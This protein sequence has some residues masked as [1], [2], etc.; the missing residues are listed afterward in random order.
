MLF[1][2]KVDS[3]MDV[4]GIRRINNIFKK[5]FIRQRDRPFFYI[6]L[7]TNGKSRYSHVQIHRIDK[8]VKLKNF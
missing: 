3:K 6:Q 1:I 7:S 4:K 5:W 2:H 8:E